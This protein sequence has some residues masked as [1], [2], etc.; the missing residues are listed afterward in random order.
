[1]STKQKS[2]SKICPRCYGRGEL[3]E[4]TGTGP[5]GYSYQRCTACKGKGVVRC[6]GISRKNAV[7]ILK[8]KLI[9]NMS[10]VLGKLSRTQVGELPGS[11]PSDIKRINNNLEYFN[12]RFPE[13]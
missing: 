7:E 1:M 8:R 13:S 2:S 9:V 12:D 5:T 11:I 4:N 3:I 6:K 10:R